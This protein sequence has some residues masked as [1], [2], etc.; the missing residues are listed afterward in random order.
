MRW[1]ITA[2][3]VLCLAGPA[4]SR[5][6]VV[7]PSGSGDFTTIQAAI[8]AVHPD[9]APD[10]VIVHP[11]D[12][13]EHLYFPLSSA[14]VPGPSL[15]VSSGGA[16]VT[17]ALDA[18]YPSQYGWLSS[19]WWI[20]RGLTFHDPFTLSGYSLGVRWEQC[21]FLD[22][23][24]A[25]DRQ[26]NPG[27]FADCDF[28][29]PASFE[30]YEG[31]PGFS[32][33]RFHHARLT[34]TRHC[35]PLQ[36][37]G[38]SFMGSP[39]DTLAVGYDEVGFSDC[40]FD[41]GSVGVLSPGPAEGALVDGC[42]FRHLQTAVSVGPVSQYSSTFYISDCRF[43]ACD[44][45]VVAPGGPV[46]MVADTLVGLG[47]APIQ[48][49]LPASF[50]GLVCEDIDGAAI[51]I[52][53][54]AGDTSHLRLLNSRFRGVRGPAVR[55]HGGTPALT[56]TGNR[57]ELGGT[58]PIAMTAATAQVAGNVFYANEGSGLALTLLGTAAEDSI[59]ENTSAFNLADGLSFVGA[60]G[61]LS[62]PLRIVRNLVAQN[63]GAGVHC[64]SDWGGTLARNDAWQNYGGQYVGQATYAILNLVEDPKFCDAPAGDLTVSAGSPCSAYTKTGPIGALGTGCDIE[65]LGAPPPAAPTVAFSA[66]PIPA[67]GRIEFAL[68]ALA[69]AARLDVLDAQGRRVW[70]AP[71]GRG[72]MS[73]RWQGERDGGGAA[74]PG[75][76]WARLVGTGP[77]QARRFIWLR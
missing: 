75:V 68:P 35:G 26:C 53:A 13:P 44:R 63:G 48:M 76:Y 66:R 55:M 25:I 5:T 39:G 34:A 31:S 38:C 49:A 14:Q 12:Y 16:A 42:L 17:S 33:L 24:H 19:Y 45:A 51:D 2:A 36:F 54:P 15:L 21:A 8:D 37:H 20:V 28:Y 73:V 61:T 74:E 50:D 10:T 22:Q 56:L 41:S 71:L 70:S 72:T 77:L 58:T 59:V 64:S 62:S 43:E 40:A 67:R 7:D 1:L 65:L 4:E 69:G 52:T 57:F 30:G 60:T 32:A 47:D 3:A 29:A 46:A 11:A 9:L 23:V 18:T 27:D 6:Y